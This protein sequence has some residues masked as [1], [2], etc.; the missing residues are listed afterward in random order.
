[1]RGLPG[2]ALSKY[3]ILAQS[4]SFPPGPSKCR[5]PK[6]CS[7]GDRA[8]SCNRRTCYTLHVHTSYL[9]CMHTYVRTYSYCTCVAEWCCE[10]YLG[11]LYLLLLV[12]HCH[13]SLLELSKKTAATSVNCTKLPT[14]L[15]TSVWMCSG[16]AKYSTYAVPL[17]PPP[18]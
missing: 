6:N 14:W 5:A 15:K 17:L 18:G 1:M 12:S 3:T 2:S 10:S 13:E 7:R 9:H 4:M 8:N 11:D 16:V